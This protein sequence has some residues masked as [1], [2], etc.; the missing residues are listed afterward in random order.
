MHLI[1]KLMFLW[2]FLFC[3]EEA[4]KEAGMNLVGI[5][6]F[7]RHDPQNFIWK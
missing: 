4:T 2:P 3:T 5:Q 1:M 7:I 6:N